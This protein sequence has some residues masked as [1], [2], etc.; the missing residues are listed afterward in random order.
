MVGLSHCAMGGDIG[1]ITMTALPITDIYEDERA[2]LAP[3]RSSTRSFERLT[4][5]HPDGTIAAWRSPACP[6]P[7]Q[8]GQNANTS[9]HLVFAHATG[10]CA[11]AYLPILRQLDPRIGVTAVD[12]R[13]HGRT[14]LHTPMPLASWQVYAD[15]LAYV[16]KTVRNEP[17]P[18]GAQITGAR[19]KAKQARGPLYLAG[20]SMGAV[21]LTLMLA[22]NPHL[23]ARLLLLEPVAMPQW[24]NR[25]AGTPAWGPFRRRFYMVVNAQNR[26]DGWASRAAVRTSYLKKRFFAEWDPDCLAG[27]LED[28]LTAAPHTDDPERR[29]RLSC[30]PQWEG[31]TFGAQANAFW[32]AAKRVA[33][34]LRVV[35]A[36]SRYSTVRKGARARFRRLG[37]DLTVLPGVDHM[38]PVCEPA[39]MVD[40]L[41]TMMNPPAS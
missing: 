10:L 25:F 33:D 30:T 38:F 13:G 7:G 20:H 27:Y 23:A 4:I 39:H 16:V 18:S 37:I 11:A 34:R 1:G 12:M 19:A 17:P 15:D 36:A 26:R 24:F 8:T 40:A 29:I 6:V 14:Q 9:P 22:R 5:D 31:A 3:T 41:Q 35:S 21:S 2:A 32:P 28:G